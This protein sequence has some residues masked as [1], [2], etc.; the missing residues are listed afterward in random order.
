MLRCDHLNPLP[1]HPCTSPLGPN[2]PPPGDTGQR[3][4]GGALGLGLL[5]GGATFSYGFRRGCRT[6]EILAINDDDAWHERLVRYYSYFGFRTV[7]RVGGNGLADVP[8]L[9]VWGGEGTRMDADMG[10]M[11]RKWT[12]A[13]RSELGLES[14]S[15]DSEPGGRRSRLA[16]SGGAEAAAAAG[17]T[18]TAAGG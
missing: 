2:P 5:L 11:L 16:A 3:I 9:L 18:G 15:E 10:A 14:E 13:F 1:P 6:A 8:H 7:C 17:G 12:P 4:R